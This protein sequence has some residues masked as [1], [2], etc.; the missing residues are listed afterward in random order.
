MKKWLGSGRTVQGSVRRRAP[1]GGVVPQ[2]APCTVTGPQG[3]GGGSMYFPFQTQVAHDD[4]FRRIGGFA[5]WVAV[6]QKC[7]HCGLR[8]VS[9]LPSGWRQLALKVGKSLALTWGVVA[10]CGV[11]VLT[12]RVAFETCFGS[13]TS[14]WL[15]THNRERLR[16]E[17]VFQHG[18]GCHCSACMASGFGGTVTEVAGPLVEDESSLSHYTPPRADDIIL[19]GNPVRWLAGQHPLAT[20]TWM[21][22]GVPVL[23]EVWLGR[24]FQQASRRYNVHMGALL[25]NQL[26]AQKQSEPALAARSGIKRRPQRYAPQSKWAAFAPVP[27]QPPPTNNTTASSIVPSR[28]LLLSKARG[29]RLMRA[30]L[31]SQRMYTSSH[32][33]SLAVTIASLE[34]LYVAVLSQ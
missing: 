14:L 8:G 9:S 10:G 2:G 18:M 7:L 6:E 27:D 23:I 33:I 13:R 5:G 11:A 17:V 21:L 3:G 32:L 24:R 22:I 19:A 29:R 30:L 12:L 28:D 1:V 26:A 31:S 20:A 4:G 15:E 25:A 16:Q 34:L